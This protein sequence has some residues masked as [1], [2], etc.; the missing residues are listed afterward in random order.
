MF[1]DD[2]VWRVRAEETTEDVALLVTRRM[3]PACTAFA[4]GGYLIHND[5]LPDDGSTDYA[6]VK[7]PT[8]R[9]GA[10]VQV[11]SLTLGFFNYENALDRLRRVL[12]GDYDGPA[13]AYAVEPRLETA[14]EHIAR[15]CQF[16]S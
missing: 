1:H 2:R 4:N 14:H 7:R 5:S 6:V 13:C 15:R 11:A 12:A 9:G 3:W 10:Y 16:C 8:E